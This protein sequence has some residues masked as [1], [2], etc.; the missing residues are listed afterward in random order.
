MIALASTVGVPAATARTSDAACRLQLAGAHSSRPLDVAGM[1]VNRTRPV[2]MPAAGGFT[3]TVT[4]AAAL[5]APRLS[6]TTSE[7]VSV[8]TAATVGAE[9]WLCVV[10]LDRVTGRTAGLRPGVARDR[11]RRGRCCRLPSSVTVTPR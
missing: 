10:V 7:K 2:T 8:V 3:V 4:D 11:C 6:V 5:L 1:R 9:R